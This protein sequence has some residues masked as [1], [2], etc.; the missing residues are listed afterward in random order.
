MY[1]P[2]LVSIVFITVIYFASQSTVDEDFLTCE[3]FNCT[4]NKYGVCAVNP[5]IDLYFLCY[6]GYCIQNKYIP[7]ENYKCIL[8]NH[9]YYPCHLPNIGFSRCS[10]PYYTSF[11]TGNILFILGLIHLTAVGF[12]YWGLPFILYKIYSNVSGIV[13]IPIDILLPM[14]FWGGVLILYKYT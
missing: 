11:G 9:I 4:Y 13:Q 8:P 1:K 10:T 6:P 12:V 2:I 7:I 14:L 3:R 5:I